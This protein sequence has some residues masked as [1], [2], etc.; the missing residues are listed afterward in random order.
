MPC[1]TPENSAPGRA[2]AEADEVL[3]AW[4]ALWQPALI[5]AAGS[6]PRWLSAETPP[7]EPAG[8]LILVPPC[9]EPLLPAGWLA[10]TEA[11]GARVLHQLRDRA[12]MT[13]A[14]RAQLE[15]Q[16]AGPTTFD[17][18]LADDFPALAYCHFAIEMLTR[19]MRYMSSLDEAGFEREVVAAARALC[20]GD[21]P[22]A[23]NRLQAA[24]DLLHTAREYFY[25][26]E[27]YLLDLTLVAGTTLGP[28]LRAELAAGRPANFLICGELV[29]ELSSREPASLAA[30]RQALEAGTAALVGGEL[31]QLELP[32]LGPEA[33]R[34]Q[35]VRGLEAY[36]RCLGTRPV[37]FGRRR[38]GMTPLLPQI[39]AQ[40]GF[41]GAMHATLDDGR[42]PADPQ[43]RIRWEGIDGSVLDAIL[44]V[45]SDVSRAEAF[46]GLPQSLGNGMDMDH[47]ATAVLAHWPGRTSPWYRD[48]QRIG[49]YTAVLGSFVTV[50][51]YFERTGMAGQ[52]K[53]LQADQYRSPY[54]VQDVAIGRRD[55]ISRWVRYFARRAAGEA[56][57][58]LEAL[59]TLAAGPA[60][61]C[62]PLGQ[63]QTA[64]P[65]DLL[66]AID[67][68]LASEPADEAALDRR[69]SVELETAAGR[70]ARSISGAA[71]GPAGGVLLLNPWSFPRQWESAVS[72]QPSAVSSSTL[73][74]STPQPLN[75]STPQPLNPSALHDIP[76]L[77]FAWVGPDCEAA[78]AAKPEPRKWGLFRPRPAEPPTLAKL[79]V[80]PHPIAAEGPGARVSHSPL[81]PGDGQGVRADGRAGQP[82]APPE[83]R[84]PPSGAVLHNELFELTIDPASGAIRS[85]F[86]YQSRGPRLAQQLAMRLC[87]GPADRDEA[88]SIMAADEVTVT[89]PGPVLGEVLVRGRLLDRQGQ[90]LAGFRQTTRVRRGS[91]VI[92]LLIELDVG[93]VPEPDPWNS[94]YAA[95]FA[96]P[97]AEAVL[98]RGVNQANLPTEATQLESP[99]FIEIRA[100]RRRTTLL[101]GGLPYHRR[102]G[103]RKLDSLLV[104]RG[105]SARTFRLAVAVDAPQPIAAALDF[106]APAS[107]RWGLARPAQPS[108]WLFHLDAR[109]VLATHWEPLAIDGRC[110]GFRVRLLETEGRRVALGLR[111]F[112]S[113]QSAYKV[114]VPG[115]PPSGLSIEG[116]RLSVELGPYEWAEVEAQFA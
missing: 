101:T 86:D 75:P 69:I 71:S 28:S 115:Q 63:A 81:P 106:L 55:P 21:A 54:L 79:V 10:E 26:I 80:A 1:Q 37:V 111:S 4:S 97:G 104:V 51:D 6:M 41:R 22:E 15:P 57:Q 95:R 60:A 9:A 53:M 116:D 113:L 25:P 108:G 107:V 12:E 24:F 90:P 89:S 36:Q 78:A 65:P 88:Y 73:I 43:A 70:L 48:F 72:R 14:A 27:A 100:D 30:L 23:R 45:P 76:P 114:A 110:Q 77:G 40:L 64:Q 56:A 82:S 11:A 18:E 66:D 16:P 38:F 74:P 102:I 3:S 68:S 7:A 35:L 52:Q 112:R 92:E 8:H 19:Q 5:A 109:N 17:P 29:E 46:Y 67:D 87:G 83:T 105:E 91:R 85:I 33:I 61:A 99:H 62:P 59:G 98:H 103:P 20:Q 49:R 42:F 93:R 96:W 32:L 50:N 2:A 84:S 47:L 44:R 34:R 58:T 39:L 13:A 94:Y 31:R